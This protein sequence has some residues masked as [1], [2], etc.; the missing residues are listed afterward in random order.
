MLIT[1]D[2]HAHLDPG[3]WGAASL[4]IGAVLAMSLSPAEAAACATPQD[5]LIAWGVGCHPRDAGAQR[6][7]APDVFRELV[8]Q[9]AIIGEVGLDGSA[10]TPPTLQLATFRHVLEVAREQPRIVSIHS[11]QA[12]D[13]V[14][15]E[16]ERTP[17]AAPILH[18]FAGT[19]EEAARAVRLGCAFS[20][21]PAVA[22]RSLFR[23]HVPLDRVL[24]ESDHGYADPPGAIPSRI[25]WVE[26]FVGQQY[27]I[28]PSEVRARGWRNLA[29]L[30]AAAGVRDLLPGGLAARL[31]D[32]EAAGHR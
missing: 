8:A 15:D 11:H 23:R 31:D 22:R 13:R 7:F 10:R 3:R 12:V 9:R 1:L 32:A 30:V 4:G 21:H 18:R 5:P 19:A 20:I 29:S 17:L 24:P 26:H 14:L 28:D 27:G 25:E 6:D 16:L 2:A